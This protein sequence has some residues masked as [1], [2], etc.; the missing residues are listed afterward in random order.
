MGL[1]ELEN[2]L[3]P[4]QWRLFL[5]CLHLQNVGDGVGQKSRQIEISL[6][7]KT[8]LCLHL[9]IWLETRK[10]AMERN[11]HKQ[12]LKKVINEENHQ[13]LF[14]DGFQK[15]WKNKNSLRFHEWQGDG[16]ILFL[17]ANK[18]F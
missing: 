9:Q 2:P 1:K 4:F 5:P 7:T 13:N 14:C 18:N 8:N 17:L 16:M 6:E 10:L 12:H 3:V 15:I 11:S